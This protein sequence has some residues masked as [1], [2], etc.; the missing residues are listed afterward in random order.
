MLVRMTWR[1]I[2]IVVAISVLLSAAITI[3]IRVVAENATF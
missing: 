1:D 2:L 3:C